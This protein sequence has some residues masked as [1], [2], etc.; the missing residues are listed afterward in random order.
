MAA[1]ETWV[2]RPFDGVGPVAFGAPR[3]EVRATCGGAH[4]YLHTYDKYRRVPQ[5]SFVT[6]G[7]SIVNVEYDDDERVLSVTVAIRP[8]T[9]PDG[10]LL[11]G[12]S[13]DEV[14]PQLRQ[15]GH[16]VDVEINVNVADLG[17]RIRT[18]FTSPS[19]PSVVALRGDYLDT[20]ARM[21]EETPD[22]EVG[23]RTTVQCVVCAA[24]AAQV[25]VIPP[26]R[27]PVL[28]ESWSAARRESFW[29]YR[30]R[31]SWWFIYQGPG[32]GN[33][34]GDAVSPAKGQ[35]YLNAFSEPV[36]YTSMTELELYDVAGF[37]RQCTQ[38]YCP[39]HWRVSGTGYGT[40]P[41]GHGQSLDPHWSPD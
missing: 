13:A 10:L 18:A 5:D 27:Y 23:V 39:A 24:P 38:P 6:P 35:Q 32:G 41:R 2:L 8:V 20:L 34:H 28:W 19:I 36:R 14:I 17:L 3:S 4:Q 16:Q 22:G 11:V 29:T 9:L 26:G 12:A 30:P 7:V 40:C 15:R 1:T 33:G 21:N 37:C 25:E 31:D